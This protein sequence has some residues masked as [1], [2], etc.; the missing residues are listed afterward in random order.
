[1]RP[2]FNYVERISRYLH[3][4]VL[5]FNIASYGQEIHHSKNIPINKKCSSCFLVKYLLMVRDQIYMSICKQFCI[6]IFRYGEKLLRSLRDARTHLK[7]MGGG[8][9]VIWD[10]YM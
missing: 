2:L 8:W 7:M 10:V 4:A 5:V 1:M 9:W 3:T 6:D